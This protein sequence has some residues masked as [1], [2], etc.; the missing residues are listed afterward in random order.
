MVSTPCARRRRRQPQPLHD[1]GV[2]RDACAA[3]ASGASASSAKRAFAISSSARSIKPGRCLRLAVGQRSS[4]SATRH[5]AG[6]A[7]RGRTHLHVGVKAPG[8]ANRTTWQRSGAPGRVSTRRRRGSRARNPSLEALARQLAGPRR[9]FLPLHR[10]L[11]PIFCMLPSLSKYD[12]STSGI[13][14]AQ[15]M[16]HYQVSNQGGSLDAR[17]GSRCVPAPASAA[18]AAAPS[19]ARGVRSVAAAA[20]PRADGHRGRDRRRPQRGRRAARRGITLSLRAHGPRACQRGSAAPERA[21]AQRRPASNSCLQ[22]VRGRWP[23]WPR[24]ERSALLRRRAARQH[25]S[26]RHCSGEQRRFRPAPPARLLAFSLARRR[27][28]GR[29]APQTRRTLPRS[30]QVLQGAQERR[31]AAPRAHRRR[32]SVL[33]LRK[34]QPW[35]RSPTFPLKSATWTGSAKCRGAGPARHAAGAPGRAQ[36][37]RVT[38]RCAA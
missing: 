9:T 4:V 21:A 7:Q 31:R 8:T 32:R 30:C 38:P 15:A 6:G 14:G 33:Q 24:R 34:P 22:S 28:R 12:S 20:H 25:A 37:L 26:Q 35:R 2:W 27:R 13:C 10:S 1:V 19:G 16:G 36:C 3:R 18:R 29:G 23:P 17:R 5:E 11:L